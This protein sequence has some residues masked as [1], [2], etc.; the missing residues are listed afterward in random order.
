MSTIF[1]KTCTMATAAA[2]DLA[3]VRGKPGE[4]LSQLAAR[5]LDQL[6]VTSWLPSGVLVFSLVVYANLWAEKGKLRAAVDRI[7][8]MP[9]GQMVLLV[10][11][12]ILATVIAQAFEFNA[13]RLLEGYWGASPLA[14]VLSYPSRAAFEWRRICLDHQRKRLRTTAKGEI[15]D[16]ASLANDPAEYRQMIKCL[17][18]GDTRFSG[19]KPYPAN[20]ENRAELEK[21]A[22][23]SGWKRHANPAT[24]RRIEAIEAAR[25]RYPKQSFNLMPTLLG[26]IM[27]S[28]EE[29]AGANVEGSLEGMVERVFHRLPTSLQVTHDQFRGRLD[30]YCTLTLLSGSCAVGGTALLWRFGVSGAM[31]A[32]GVS[33][34]LS[35]VFYRAAIATAPAYGEV[36]L[37]IRAFLA[38]EEAS[39]VLFEQ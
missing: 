37:T 31:A 5:I 22:V 34:V 16:A 15:D 28:F 20:L 10:G 39:P 29:R 38:T 25:A 36:L 8:K 4:S 9:T 1:R 17:V 7:A 12:V 18:T 13:I 27:R 26:N 30:L 23:A 3:E 14:R 6:S 21:Q 19:A 33:L 35:R 32:G 11:A 24:V 2:E